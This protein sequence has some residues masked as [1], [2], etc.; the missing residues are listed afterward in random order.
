MEVILGK[1]ISLIVPVFNRPDYLRRCIDSLKKLNPSPTGIIYVDDASTNTETLSII[2]NELR[3][4]TIHHAENTGVRG[5]IKSGCDLSFNY[6][7]CDL[8]IVLDSDAI[9]KPDLIYKLVS[10]HV[11]YGNITSAFNTP[12]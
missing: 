12:N 9:V 7:G 10:F 11:K 2:E 4:Q 1:K 5:S 6:H 8:A 3:L